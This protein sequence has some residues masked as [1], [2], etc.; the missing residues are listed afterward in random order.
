MPVMRRSDV[1]RAVAEEREGSVVVA[2]MTV[3]EPFRAVSPSTLNVGCVGFMGGASALGLGVALAQPERKVLV[4]DGDGSLLMQLGSLATISGSEAPNFFHF[5]FHNGVYETSGSQ[6]IPAEGRIDF[7]G[8]AR[9]AGYRV[10]HRF[11]DLEELRTALHGILQEQGPVFVELDVAPE[12]TGY[13]GGVRSITFEEECR[14]LRA[15]LAG[16]T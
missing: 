13:Q 14:Q 9:A 10:C 3:L 15:A 4:L 1:L 6:K 7:A 2:T 8:M 11:S 12:G 5:L 16:A